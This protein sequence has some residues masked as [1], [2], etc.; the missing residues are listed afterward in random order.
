[1]GVSPW[2]HVIVP[3]RPGSGVGCDPPTSINVALRPNF[4]RADQWALFFSRLSPGM[5]AAGVSKKKSKF[6]AI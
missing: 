2:V 5:A 3:A 6:Y 4:T 1:M